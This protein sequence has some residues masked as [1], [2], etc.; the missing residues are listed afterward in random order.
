VAVAKKDAPRASGKSSNQQAPKAV[1][2]IVRRNFIST[3]C[4]LFSCPRANTSSAFAAIA[5]KEQK[6]RNRQKV[7]VVVIKATDSPKKED[8]KTIYPEQVDQQI[9]Y[10]IDTRGY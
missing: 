10:P 5:K 8:P 6:R 1:S 2:K 4:G 7:V 9:N 3:C